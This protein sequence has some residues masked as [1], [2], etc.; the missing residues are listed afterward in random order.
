MI[1]YHNL[2]GAAHFFILFASFVVQL[3]G[4]LNSKISLWWS[5]FRGSYTAYLDTSS[6]KGLLVSVMTLCPM[7][8]SMMMFLFQIWI[9]IPLAGLCL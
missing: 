4:F 8:W 7:N 9:L 1:L 3:Q 5:W 6:L 2:D